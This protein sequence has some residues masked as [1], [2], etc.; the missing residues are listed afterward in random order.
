MPIQA[1]IPKRLFSAARME[2]VVDNY[3][4]M[5]ADAIKIDF[6]VTTRTWKRRPVFLVRKS[7]GER[8]IYTN[9]DIYKFVS[10]GTRVRY[11]TMTPGFVAKTRVRY[12]GS[13]MGRG[14]VLFISKRHPRPGI[15]AREFPEAIIA[16]WNEEAPR[17]MQ[18]AIDAEVSSYG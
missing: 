18:R 5:T 11:A 17:Q 13:R 9:S 2:R 7:K 14:G 10:G 4:T 6:D 1:I 3:L 15:K 12:I 16:K 8:T